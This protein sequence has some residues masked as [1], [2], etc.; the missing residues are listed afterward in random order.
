M[1]SLGLSTLRITGSR[2]LDF[3]WALRSIFGF[4]GLDLEQNDKMQ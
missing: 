2:V 4:A 3:I 1:F